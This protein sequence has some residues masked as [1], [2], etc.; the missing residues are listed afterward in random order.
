MK[1]LKLSPYYYPEKISSTHLTED[2]EEESVKAG[3]EI[4]II[5]PRPTRGI[6]KEIYLKYKHNYYEEK[7]NK[8]IKIYRFKM[9]KERKSTITRLIRYIL[10]NI[11][12]YKKAMKQKDVDLIIGGSTPPTQGLLCTLVKKKLSKKYHR[13][14]KFIYNLQDVFP[15]SLE[16]TKICSKNSIIYKLGTIREHPN[17]QHSSSCTLGHY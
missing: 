9:F 3:Y 14:I 12:Q 11:I 2:I 4:T 10:V 7:N 15:D 16:T 13:N 8:R 17:C 5:C 1:I 6:P